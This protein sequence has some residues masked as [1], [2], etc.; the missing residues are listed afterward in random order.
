MKNKSRTRILSLAY[1]Y[2]HPNRQKCDFNNPPAPGKVCGVDLEELGVC[3]P[4]NY[5]GIHGSSACVFLKLRNDPS[6]TPEYYNSTELP[7]D[8][9]YQLQQYINRNDASKS[10]VCLSKLTL[11][12]LTNAFHFT[13]SCLGFMCRWITGRRWKCWNNF[14]H[15]WKRLSQN[16]Y[17][18]RRLGTFHRNLF[19]Q[20]EK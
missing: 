20:P 17:W 10:T 2:P 7:D 19:G 12:T 6:W 4:S 11:P 1:R 14:L 3:A 8:M 16:C 13:E 18:Q 15:S 9:P 5:Y